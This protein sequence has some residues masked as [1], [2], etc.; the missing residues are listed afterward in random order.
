MPRPAL[1]AQRIVSLLPS[2]TEL[3]C[4][5]GLG[6]RLVGVT[7]ECDG[8]PEVGDLPP[9]T[10]TLIPPAATSGEIDALV[11]ER[12]EAAGDDRPALYTLD[13]DALAA[14]DPDLIVTQ[15]LCDVCAVAEADVQAAACRLP[16]SPRVLNLEPTTLAGVFASIDAVGCAAGVDA[17]PVVRALDA[18]VRAVTERVSGR[19]RPRVVVLEWLDPPFS[20]GHWNPELVRLAGGAEV[21]GQEGAPSRTLDWAEVVRAAPDIVVVACCGFTP[22]RAL[23]DVGAF[24]GVAGWETVPAARDGRVVVVD[25]SGLFARP[26][27]RLVEAVELL[28]HLFHPDV[29]PRPDGVAP[30][31]W[32]P[33]LPVAA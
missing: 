14:L 15:A 6:D 12:F 7:H 10:R 31:V 29:Q 25:G 1:A 26:G 27:P 2:A 19:A 5:L 11:R 20:A 17:G 18:R 9:V 23:K 4:A 30:P 28:A 13:E 33:G 21:I 32:L 3:V 16:G 8:P 24:D 22:E